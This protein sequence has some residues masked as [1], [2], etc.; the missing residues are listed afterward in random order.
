MHKMNA[1]ELT[2]G[3]E[4][5]THVAI[6]TVAVGS[7]HQGAAVPGLPVGW[8]AKGDSSIR[9]RGMREGCEFVS[10]V[11][12]GADGVRNL[13]AG[14]RG[15]NALGA[16]VNRSCGLHVHV[17]FDRGNQ[18][19]L[20]R[21]VTLVANFET[22]IFA[23]TGTKRRERGAYCRGVRQHGSPEN[24]QRHAGGMRYHVLNLTNLTT[25]RRPTVEFRAFAGTTSAR[26]ILGYVRLC[27]GLVE[28]ALAAKRAT[29][30]IPKRPVES[31][32]ITRGGLGETELN[33]LM[34]QLGWTKGRAKQTY[35]AV[36]LDVAG[37]ADIQ[38]SKRELFRLARKYDRE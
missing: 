14:I 5:E 2:F 15:I 34:Y 8:I 21:L 4:I 19:A 7:Y 35:G 22:A 9:A 30:F 12:K 27:L 26:K 38:A 10:P 33:R 17:G 32:P 23:S 31:S 1:N 37:A 13:L 20:A 24:A 29:D 11:L 16:R 6:G 28:R 25:G 18:E 36:G 3:V